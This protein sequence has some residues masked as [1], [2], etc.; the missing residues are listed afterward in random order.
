MEYQKDFLKTDEE[1][2]L[3]KVLLKTSSIH[4]KIFLNF[5]ESGPINNK[6]KILLFLN[7]M[8]LFMDTCM[9]Q[10]LMNAKNNIEFLVDGLFGDEV[11][12]HGIYRLNELLNKGN[13]FLFIYELFCLRKNR[14]IFS[15]RRQLIILFSYL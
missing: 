15:L 2:Y 5:N 10:F 8:V 1:F 11:I 9:K 4:K 12:S 14:V 7:H 3:K 6:S 13:I